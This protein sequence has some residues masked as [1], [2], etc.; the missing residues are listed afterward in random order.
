MPATYA[1]IQGLSGQE[2]PGGI[3]QFVWYSPTSRFSTIQA[4]PNLATAT[5]AADLA[6]VSTAHTFPANTGFLKMYCT[7]GKG[8]GNFKNAA[9]VDASGGFYE[10]SLFVPGSTPATEGIL[11]LMKGDDLIFIVPMADGKNH[12]VGTAQHPAKVSEI[13]FNTAEQGS[14]VRGNMIKVRAFQMGPITYT[15]TITPDPNA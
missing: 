9:D 14:G 6:S 13:E 5:T 1:S 10:I 12:Q 2:N 11:R 4:P 15:A 3:A 7:Q 8:S